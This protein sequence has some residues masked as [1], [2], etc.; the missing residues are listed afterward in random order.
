VVDP[1]NDFV[2]SE[3]ALSIAGASNPRIIENI[4]KLL[5]SDKFDLKIATQDWHPDNHVSFAKTNGAELFTQKET[6][7][8]GNKINQVMWPNHCVAGTQGAEFFGPINI[9]KVDMILR[10]GNIEN[11]ECYS[12]FEYANEITNKVCANVEDLP[13]TPHFWAIFG[14]QAK[15]NQE[16][17]ICGYA[18][19]YCVA[20]TAISAKFGC[21]NI[22]VI[23]EASAA[24]DENN[25]MGIY[26]KFDTYGIKLGKTEDYI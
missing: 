5:N 22:V 24:V 13:L 7:Q 17:V 1:Q 10:K 16:I 23:P 6:E 3:G 20:Q 2:S 18:T 19:D 25:L 4:N 9:D 26:D 14:G 12:V 11:R 21:N 8:A 15:E